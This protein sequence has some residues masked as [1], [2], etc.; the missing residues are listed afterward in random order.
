[1]RIKL[2]G[3]DVTGFPIAKQSPKFFTNNNSW[4]S[5]GSPYSRYWPDQTGEYGNISADPLFVDT[6]AGDYHLQNGSPCIDAGRNDVPGLAD[7]AFD[8]NPRIVDGSGI[9]SAIM[10]LGAYEF[11]PIKIP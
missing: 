11:Q 3:A 10:D 2:A 8:G 7:Y 5:L 6:S 4:N 9:E 1:L